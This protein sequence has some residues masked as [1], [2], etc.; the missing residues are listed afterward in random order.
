[1]TPPF[2]P[3]QTGVL[4]QNVWNGGDTPK[5]VLNTPPI[6]LRWGSPS[7]VS[8]LIWGLWIKKGGSIPS[9]KFWEKIY[10]NG[11]SVGTPHP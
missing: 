4:R 2:I 3:H 7:P 6:P 1:M 5:M 9:K 11:G 10:G 8:P